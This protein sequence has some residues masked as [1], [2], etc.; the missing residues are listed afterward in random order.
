MNI[1][2]QKLWKIINEGS[3]TGGGGTGMTDIGDAWPD[4]IYTR[5]GER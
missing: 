5:Y 2:E 4:G 1:I 3:Q